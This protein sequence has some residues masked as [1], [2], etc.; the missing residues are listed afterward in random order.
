MSVIRPGVV[1]RGYRGD[2]MTVYP[3]NIEWLLAFA[4]NGCQWAIDALPDAIDRKSLIECETY[5]GGCI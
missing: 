2:E 1:V 4:V 3:S 5:W